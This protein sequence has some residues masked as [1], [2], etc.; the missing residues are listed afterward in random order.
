MFLSLLFV[1]SSFQSA[2]AANLT[3]CNPGACWAEIGSPNYTSLGPYHTV[4]ITYA[5]S[6][7]AT[8]TGIVFMVV[9]NYL[10]QTVEISTATLTLTAGTNGMAFPIAFGLAQGQYSAT[11]FTTSAAGVAITSTT[12]V[13]I[14]V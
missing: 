14:T 3:S 1:L 10:G 11:L 7:N 2:T 12:T 5:N 6:A 8:M 9:H 4:E 13:S